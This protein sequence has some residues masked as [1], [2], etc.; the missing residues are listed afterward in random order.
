MN[1]PAGL[2]ADVPGLDCWTRGHLRMEQPV[3]LPDGR[4][5]WAAWC[6]WC[7][8]SVTG[9]EEPGDGETPGRGLP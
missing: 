1:P 5:T 6:S 3:S 8:T 4:T 7:G 2:R 9:E